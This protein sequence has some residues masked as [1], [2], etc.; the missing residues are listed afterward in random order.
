MRKLII[1]DLSTCVG[2]NRCIRV[3]PVE[4]ANVAFMENGAIKVRINNDRCIAC[5]ACIQACRH[6][7]RDYE[8][9]T[10]RF[11]SDLSNGA[12]ISMFAAPAGRANLEEFGRILAWLRQLGVRNIFDVSLGAD[13]CTWAHIRFIQKNQPASV[14]TQPCPAIV[15]YI[16]MYRPELIPNL[17]PIHSPMLCTAIYMKKNKNITDSLA[18]L[19]PCI[20]KADEFDATGLAKYNVTF[21]KLRD[22]IHRHHITLPQQPGSFDSPDSVLGRLYSMPG[23]LKENVEFYL[24]KALRIDKCEGQAVVYR[25]LDQ[26]SVQK[27]DHLP[28]IFDVLNCPEGCNLGTGCNHHKDMFEI[29]SIMDRERK[30]VTQNREKAYFDKLY[31]TFDHI[32]NLN[33]FV[34]HYT[35]KRVYTQTITGEDIEKGF[36]LLGKQTSVQ[37]QFDCGACGSDSCRNMAGKVAIGVNTP[38]NCIEKTRND[39]QSE[40]AAVLSIQEKNINNLEIILSDISNVKTLS[41]DILSNIQDVNRAFKQYGTMAN[42]IDLIAMHIN[43]IS[44]NASVEAAR[45]GVHGKAFAV[46]A[47][48]IRSLAKSSKKTVSETAE[49]SKQAVSSTGAINQMIQ[50]ISQAVSKTYD[51]IQNISHRPQSEPDGSESAQALSPS[52]VEA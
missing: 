31:E 33:D 32:F 46:V 9:D 37:R 1:N 41:D 12:R 24:G 44:L 22:Y 13:I 21:K 48:E 27:K 50:E 30:Q 40:H 34:R 49:V 16:Q 43:I 23:G 17:S 20:A 26:F 45:A 52:R 14:I 39:I 36:E 10:E 51:T 29:N 47:E 11:L 2:C 28:A 4:E 6:E 5:G 38:M 8:D 15:K 3:C 7:S 42:E 19:S 18:V 35:S 25:A